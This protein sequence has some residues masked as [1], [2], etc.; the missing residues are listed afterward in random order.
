MGCDGVCGPQTAHL[1]PTEHFSIYTPVLLAVAMIVIPS[2][3]AT[4]SLALGSMSH[5]LGSATRTKLASE[6]KVQ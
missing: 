2:A 4:A 5:P 6:T 1:A 3:V